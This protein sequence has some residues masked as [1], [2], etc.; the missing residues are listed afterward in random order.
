MFQ[1]QLLNNRKREFIYEVLPAFF[2]ISEFSSNIFKGFWVP[3]FQTEVLKFG[4][5][6]VETHSMCQRSIEV[7]C[8]TCNFYL[9]IWRKRIQCA[10]IMQ[11][12]SKFYQYHPYIIR[13]CKQHF[14]EVFCLQGGIL[15]E[16]T[17]NFSEPVNNRRNLWT[18]MKFNFFEG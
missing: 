13:K 16:N 11:P 7:N 17:C 10:H 5:Y 15:I 1:V 4:F 12:V 14:S 6:S 2:S 9:F 18:K 8:F 3:V